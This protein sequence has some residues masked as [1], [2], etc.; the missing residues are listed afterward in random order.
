MFRIL[1]IVAAAGAGGI[2]TVALHQE[3][4]AHT[5]RTNAIIRKA[6]EMGLIDRIQGERHG[7]GQFAPVFNVITEKGRKL[8]ASAVQ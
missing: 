4:G 6:H 1:S 3:L 7:P 8:L 2:S 5:N